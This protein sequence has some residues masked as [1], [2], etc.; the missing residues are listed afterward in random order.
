MSKKSIIFVLFGA[1]GD[2]A[3][4]KIFPA[5][6]ALTDEGGLGATPH[7]IAV[8]RRDWTDAHLH[9]FLKEKNASLGADFLKHVSYANVDIE[10]GEGFDGLVT[11]VKK[12]QKG[13]SESEVVYYTSLAP[14]HQEKAIMGLKE[15]GLLARPK[16]GADA[17]SDRPRLLIE[18]PFGTDLKTAKKLDKMLLAFLEEDQIF[19]VDHYLAKD[20]MLGIMNLREKTPEFLDVISA[21]TVESIRVRIFEE[22]GIDSRGASYDGVGAFRDVGQNHL[23]EMLAVVAADL[24]K[25]VGRGGFDW[26]AART[27]VF[28]A[29]MPPTKT[30]DLSRRGQYE[31]YAKET[32]VKP[33][34]ETETAFEVITSLSSGR[35]KGAQLILEAGKKMG[36]SEAVIEVTFKESSE[37]PHSMTFSIQPEQEIIVENADGSKDVFDIAK[38]RDAYGNLIMDAVLGAS[39]SFVGSKE[40]EALWSYADRVVACWSKVPLETYSSS[41]PF[42]SLVK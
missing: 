33:G 1:T 22:K 10:K 29:L 35:L 31:G 7:I 9:T 2:L 26:A 41:K 17:V 23:L 16:G 34:S 15:A 6:Q 42:I 13:A 24:P 3:V 19:R 5:L 39:R 36:V 25:K 37:L 32:G 14:T 28:E 27:A 21:A 12:L 30:C 18:K 11:I 4:K 8:S 20:T 40:I 38:T